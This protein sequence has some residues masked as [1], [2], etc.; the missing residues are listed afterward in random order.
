MDSFDEYLY[1]PYWYRMDA[2]LLALEFY[3]VRDDDGMLI[4]VMN[5]REGII[6]LGVLQ[7]VLGFC[8]LGK[9]K[10]VY[11]ESHPK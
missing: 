4:F 10:L 11:Q 6:G 3:S 7:I 2:V 1:Y 5:Y 9:S 8:F